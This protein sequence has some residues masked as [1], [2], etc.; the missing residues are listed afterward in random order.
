MKKLVWSGIN[1]MKPRI[2]CALQLGASRL[3][4]AAWIA[5]AC[6]LVLAPNA[7]AQ[8]MG[9]EYIGTSKPFNPASC[10]T[11]DKKYVYWAAKDQVFRFK[12]DPKEPLY[13]RGW[14]VNDARLSSNWQKEVPPA[15]MPTEPEGCYGNPLRAGIVPYMQ[16]MAEDE[17]LRLFGRQPKIERSHSGFFSNS[18]VTAWNISSESSTVNLLVGKDCWQRSPGFLECLVSKGTDRS[19]YSITRILKIV[20]ALPL[21]QAGIRDLYISISDDAAAMVNRYGQLAESRVGLFD[22]VLLLNAL[23]IF[24]SEIDKL[25]PYHLWLVRYVLDAH[26]PGYKWPS[27]QHQLTNDKEELK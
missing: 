16:T 26:I 21:K 10:K 3:A 25:K 9:Q 23:R 27:Q 2:G 8:P 18:N 19:D 15:P 1:G 5:L 14:W 7:N 13:P 11:G 6:L 20:D 12:F 4:T 22:N 24:P 17:L